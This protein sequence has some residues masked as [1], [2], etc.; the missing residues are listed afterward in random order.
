MLGVAIAVGVLVG[1][2]LG[3]L[4][5]GGSILT[6]PALVYL[7]RQ[8]THAAT[9]GSLIIVGITALAGAVVHG[10]RGRVRFLAGTTF[11]L[12]GVAGSYLGSKASAAVEQHVLLSA[13]AGLM[14]VAA[15]AMLRR[16]PGGAE[17][18]RETLERDHAPRSE[19]A[20]SRPVL[21][22]VRRR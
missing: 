11:G 6:V 10:R 19:T 15:L 21:A 2:S 12:L 5:G 14:L 17:V 7:L 16:Q 22:E 3:A 13:F 8:D 20:T 1:V 9:T 18:E 4:G